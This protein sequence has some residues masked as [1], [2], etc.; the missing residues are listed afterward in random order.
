MAPDPDPQ[1]CFTYLTASFSEV[2]EEIYSRFDHI[3]CGSKFLYF[4]S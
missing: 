3:K 4:W 1:H 2:Q